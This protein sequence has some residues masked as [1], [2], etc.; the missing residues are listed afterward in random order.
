MSETQSRRSDYDRT[1]AD[2]NRDETLAGRGRP[3]VSV[4]IPTF[5]EADNIEV[6]LDQLRIRLD[7]DR[8]GDD[9][10]IIV[11]DDDSPDETWRL[12]GTIAE[13]DGRVSVVRR[14]SDRGLASAV[15]TGLSVAS[16]SVLVVMDADLQHDPAVVPRLV[17][18]VLDG[19][20][21]ICVAS[22]TSGGGS[23]GRFARSRKLISFTGNSVAQ[24]LLGTQCTDPMSGFFAVSRTYYETVAPIINPRGFKILLEFLARGKRP[25]VAEVGYRFGERLGGETKLNRSVVLNYLAALITLSAGRILPATFV[26]YLAVGLVG[27]GVRAVVEQV[28]LMILDPSSAAMAVVLAV[29]SGLIVNYL[30]HNRITFEP[31]RHR[32]VHTLRGLVSFHVVSLHGLLVHAGVMA[33]LAPSGPE[34]SADL[35]ATTFSGPFILAGALATIGNYHINAGTTWQT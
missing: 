22:R 19:G 33:M 21:D 1:S 23:F 17:A 9:Y 14:A 24:L 30:L 26:I 10:E 31:F 28:G 15:L 29:E 8:Y 4:I 3:T 35:V 34:P 13:Q 18:P 25:Q 27:L 20:S 7:A 5:N 16:G 11:V 6:L 12:A 2:R 32:G